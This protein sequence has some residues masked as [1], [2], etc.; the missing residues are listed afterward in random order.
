MHVNLVCDT[1]QYGRQTAILSQF[2]GFLNQN[3]N[4]PEPILF[5]RGTNIKYY[6]IHMNINLFHI[7]IQY[8]YETLPFCCKYFMAFNLNA[9][10]SDLILFKLDTKIKYNGVL[11]QR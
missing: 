1:I 3:L 8:G 2:F 4:I 10:I 9:N 6:G 5:K 7:M 11:V